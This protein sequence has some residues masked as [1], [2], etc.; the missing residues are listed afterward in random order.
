MRK[1]SKQSESMSDVNW[2][3]TGSKGNMG[4]ALIDVLEAQEVQVYGIDY[5]RE[6]RIE[7]ISP[8]YLFLEA[9]LIDPPDAK[10]VVKVILDR[11][12][13]IDVW[14]N[15]VGGFAMGSGVEDTRDQDWQHMY[16]INFQTALNCCR[17]VLP[18]MKQRRFGHI[19]NFGSVAGEDGLALAGPYAMSKAAVLSLTRTVA[20]EGAESGVTCN[21]IVPSTMD[22]HQNRSAMPDADFSSWTSPLAIAETILAVVDSN[23]NGEF[24]HV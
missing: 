5:G 13:K 22:T 21:A 10:R 14:I 8:Q 7:S 15:T 9:D 18:H 17:A 3:I 19:I 4:I 2:V 24:I 20:Q 12:K 6:E 16:N 23:Q 1:P 11:A